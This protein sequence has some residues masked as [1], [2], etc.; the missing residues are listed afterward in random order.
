MFLK[1]G[2][3]SV[4]DPTAGWGGRMLG[5]WVMGIDYTGVDTNTN[6]K[7]AYDNMMD[8]LDEYNNMGSPSLKLRTVTQNVLLAG[9]SSQLIT[10]KLNMTLC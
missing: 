6:M 4:L 10:V 7:I 9:Q 8:M 1:Y 5:A 3:T 2:V